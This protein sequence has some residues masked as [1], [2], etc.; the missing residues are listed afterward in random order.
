VKKDISTL[1]RSAERDLTITDGAL[2]LFL[3]VVEAVDTSEPFTLTAKQAGALCG[4]TDK[5]TLYARIHQ[6]CPKYLKPLGVKGCPPAAWFKIN[7]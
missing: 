6:L 2:R 7:L 3:R 4:L 5:A 1:R